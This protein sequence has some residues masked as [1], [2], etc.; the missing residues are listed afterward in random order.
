A[1]R[2]RLTDSQGGDSPLAFSLSVTR[3]GSGEVQGL[4]GTEVDTVGRSRTVVAGSDARLRVDGVLLTR[5]SNTISDALAGVTLT[6]QN[7][8]VGTTVGVT[9]AH[10]LDRA[11]KATQDFAM[12]YNNVLA[13]TKA[14]SVPGAPL[15]SN[16]TLRA[17]MS[18]LTNVMLTDVAGLAGSPYS[19][20]TLAGVS[21]SRTGTL[22]VDATALK[23]ALGTNL[24]AVRALFGR[25][26]SPTDA[27]V[28]FVTGG[29][30]TVPGRYAV[31]ITA[32][33]TRGAVTGAGFAGTYADDGTADSITITDAGG[34]V[35]TV[36]LRNGDSLDA[37]VTR[38]N[39]DFAARGMRLVASDV[40]GQLRLQAADHGS[41][42]AFT[43]AYAG[44][45]ADGSAQLGLA[46][47]TYT[48][49]DVAG[50]IG[51]HAATGRGQVLTGAVGTAVAGLAVSYT[52]TT[53]RSAGEIGYALG[54]AGMM[55]RVVDGVVRN[56][57]GTVAVQNT[58]IETSITS[59]QRRADDVQARLERRRESL[60]RQFTAMES[61]ISRM[62]A[63]GS[64]LASQLKMLQGSDR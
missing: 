62:N 18:S 24:D 40:G 29:E 22:D 55:E 30:G 46:A 44:G 17:A 28:S 39:A 35:S 20:A 37:I 64:W 3:A 27:Q 8:E 51:G 6:L 4:G 49:T 1:G 2:I 57:D 32:A 52:G 38:L 25:G 19:R 16:G 53:A 36:E 48:G 42:P 58:S 60:V 34:K 12:A 14:Q 13:F 61:A 10:D 5:G 26:G 33:A 31:E 59:L 7:A 15:A 41:A 9:V 21:L 54:V 50:T 11:V 63:Q 43:V 56:G 45:G 23:A 47:G